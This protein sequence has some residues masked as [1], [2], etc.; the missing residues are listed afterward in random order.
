MFVFDVETLDLESS[1][2]VLSFS[3]VHVDETVAYKTLSELYKDVFTAKLNVAVQYQDKRTASLEVG[4]W[5]AKQSKEAKEA[6]LLPNGT[7]IH[8]IR[9]ISKYTDWVTEVI[10][11]PDENVWTRGAFDQM[12]FE[13]LCRTYKAI[14]P[15][16]YNRY[17]DIRTLLDYK[18]RSD[19]GYVEIDTDKLTVD[20]KTTKHNPEDDVVMD[21]AR[22]LY[23][24]IVN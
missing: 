1:A 24:K 5:W 8:P 4:E 10:K 2:V 11:Y 15:F 21:A 9:A 14:P 20:V 23:G 19:T 18:Y 3:C 7:E 17:R 22:I 13:S 16:R 12:I 6:S